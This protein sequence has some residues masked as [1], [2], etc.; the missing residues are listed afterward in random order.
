MTAIYLDYNATTPIA[1]EAVAAMLPF[2]REHFGN[3]SSIHA[4]GDAPRMAM[5]ESRQEIARLIGA[6]PAEIIF[7]GSA[8]EANN[9][10]ILGLAPWG[11]LA[12]TP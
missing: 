12:V 11:L 10:A 6:Q 5:A 1:S 2:L 8:T 7:T 3:P 9:L 4:Y